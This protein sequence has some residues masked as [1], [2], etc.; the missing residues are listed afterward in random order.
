VLGVEFSEPF[1]PY[2][3]VMDLSMPKMDG[4]MAIKEI[5]K[6]APE[7]KILV[8]TM[9][10]TEENILAALQ[11]DADG[12]L[13]KENSHSDLLTAIDSILAGRFHLSPGILSMVV[14]GY[15]ETKKIC[16]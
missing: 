12:Y 4:T 6:Q 14:K 3:L 15:S 2:L 1:K 7:T 8:F 16:N 5:K 11:G 9:C 13:L 10:N